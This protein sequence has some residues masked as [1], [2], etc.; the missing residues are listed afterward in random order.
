MYIAKPRI[1]YWSLRWFKRSHNYSS[2][3]TWWIRKI[4]RIFNVIFF[5]KNVFYVKY[6]NTRDGKRQR[7][8]MRMRNT[9]AFLVG[10]W[11]YLNSCINLYYCLIPEYSRHSIKRRI[12]TRARKACMWTHPRAKERVLTR[13][14]GCHSQSSQGAIHNGIRWR[15]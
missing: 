6:K 5:E 1:S 8:T 10:L 11:V 4:D 7:L 14:P 12:H 9:C 13:T 2:E 3:N 15:H